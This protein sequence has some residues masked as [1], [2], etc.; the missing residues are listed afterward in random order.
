[1]KGPRVS[2]NVKE[3]RFEGALAELESKTFSRGLTLVFIWNSTQREKFNSVFQEFSA[4]IEKS[5]NLASRLG[6]MLSLCEV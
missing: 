5:F 4:S 6:T 1:M 3:I 2:K